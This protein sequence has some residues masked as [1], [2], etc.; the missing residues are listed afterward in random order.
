[1]TD[2]KH[3][4]RQLGQAGAERHVVILEHDLAELVGVVSG[5]HQHGGQ[6]RRI[7]RWFKA[8]HLKAPMGNRGT[9]GGREALVAGKHLIEPLL[10]QHRDGFAQAVKQVGGGGIGEEA[11]RVGLEHLFPIPVRAR[12]LV[13]LRSRPRLF[14]DGVEAEPRRQHKSLLRT[15]DGDVDF[16]LVVVVVD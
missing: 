5:R 13:G 2:A 10:E 16:P 7:L 4:A 1:M 15:A 11:G 12:H 14:G 3:L 6:H 8:Q 9:G